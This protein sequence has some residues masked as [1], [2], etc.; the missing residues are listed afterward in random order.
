MEEI[1]A[2]SPLAN[3]DNNFPCR[4]AFVWRLSGQAS[5]CSPLSPESC[6]GHSHCV[7]LLDEDMLH[8]RTSGLLLVKKGASLIQGTLYFEERKHYA[9]IGLHW[10]WQMT[11]NGQATKTQ[12]YLRPHFINITHCIH[13]VCPKWHPTPYRLRSKV[14]HYTGYHFRRGQCA[15][16][17]G[18]PFPLVKKA[19]R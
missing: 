9:H 4:T 6:N 10:L 3:F 19:E 17:P 12:T 15:T 2:N 7:L 5:I 1:A 14:V 11:S 16:Q 13:V 8:M 18:M